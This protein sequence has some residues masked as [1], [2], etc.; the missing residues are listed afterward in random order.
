MKPEL[1]DQL[2]EAIY[3]IDSVPM[4]KRALEA[5]I[6]NGGDLEKIAQYA[7]TFDP[8]TTA[9]IYV[10]LAQASGSYMEP[11]IRR[12]KG[13]PIASARLAA[14]I[15]DLLKAPLS[16][17]EQWVIEWLIG[18]AL[19]ISN[20]VEKCSALTEI[21]KAAAAM[22]SPE[23]SVLLHSQGD[24]TIFYNDGR[25]VVNTTKSQEFDNFTEA[26]AATKEVKWSIL[27]R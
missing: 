27:I 3:T 10:V 23:N 1:F 22:G 25:Y 6:A 14:H 5:L 11:A 12:L 17:S 18:L 13:T 26:M 4:K 8:E 16:N 19:N 21:A 24:K 9:E 7:D 20:G 15:K 2:L